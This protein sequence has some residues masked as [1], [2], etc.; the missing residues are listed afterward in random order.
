VGQFSHRFT[1]TYL[2][3]EKMSL[4]LYYSPGACSFVPHCLLQAS[5][6]EFEP[7]LIKLH[8]GEQRTAEFLAMNSHGQ[9]PVLVKDDHVLTQITAMCDY[10]DEQYAQQHFYPTDPIAK[11]QAKSVLAWMNNTVH[12]TFTHFFMPAKYSEDQAVQANIKATAVG[13]Y[14]KLIQEIQAIVSALPSGAWLSGSHFGPVDAYCLTLSRWAG[15]TGLD[16]QTLP[17]LWAHVQR[18]AAH[19]PVAQVIERERLQ[20]LV[21]PL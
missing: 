21:K 4:A 7:R 5:G 19:P 20:L 9:V 16:L 6:A 12:P 14:A 8:K 13:Q 10:L 3:R 1:S 18:V 2:N 15:F 11:A 17:V